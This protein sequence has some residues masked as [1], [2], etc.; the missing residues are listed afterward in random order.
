MKISEVIAE[1]EKIREE[2]GDLPVVKQREDGRWD[3]VSYCPQGRRY[4]QHHE[5]GGS[6]QDLSVTLL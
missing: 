1:L 6:Y 2:L 4:F 5:D 3:E